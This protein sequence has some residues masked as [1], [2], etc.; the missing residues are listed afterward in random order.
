MGAFTFTNGYLM[1]ASVDFS[2]HMRSCSI[3]YTAEAPESTAMQTTTPPAKARLGGLTDWKA[4][5]ELNQDFAAL[6]VHATLF[7]LVGTII[8]CVF[9]PVTGTEGATNPKFTGNAILTGYNPMGGKVGDVMITKVELTGTGIL[10]L[11]V[12]P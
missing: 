4:S 1:L 6:K 10:A 3:D 2:D 8:A 7:P 11:D 12:T 5:V 9:Q